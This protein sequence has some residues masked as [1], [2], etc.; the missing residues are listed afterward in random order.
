MPPSVPHWDYFFRMDFSQHK[1]LYV[2]LD[3]K[4]NGDWNNAAIKMFVKI[5]QKVLVLSHYV[6]TKKVTMITSL[7]EKN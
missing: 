3:K 7:E 4:N 1:R 6:D 5:I 2:V